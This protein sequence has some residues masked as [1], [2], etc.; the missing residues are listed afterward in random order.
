MVCSLGLVAGVS[1][2]VRRGVV[3]VTNRARFGVCVLGAS[4]GVRG[5]QMLN[6]GFRVE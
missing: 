2:D 4:S 1:P 6:L 5:F 3:R